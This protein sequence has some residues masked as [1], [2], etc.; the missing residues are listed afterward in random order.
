MDIQTDGGYAMALA[1]IEELFDSE[2]GTPEEERLEELTLAVL[3]YESEHF[4][5][6]PPTPKGM[7]EYLIDA[8]RFPTLDAHLV[9][10]WDNWRFRLWWYALWPGYQFRRLRIRWGIWR[11]K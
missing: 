4:P 9:E 7:V 3:E 6:P 11:R 1:Q 2:P 5:I 10:L 8:G